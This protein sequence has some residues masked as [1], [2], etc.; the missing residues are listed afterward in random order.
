LE[1]LEQFE[2][3]VEEVNCEVLIAYNHNF[4]SN[5]SEALQLVKTGLIGIPRSIHVRWLEHWGGIF[6]AH[7]WLDGPSDTYLGFSQRGGGAC[8]E[9]SHAI[10]L[11]QLFASELGLGQV[12]S[13]FAMMDI[14]NEGGVD[15]DRTAQLT[16]RTT[17]GFTGTVI[18]D[19]VTEPAEKALRIQGDG[20]YLEWYVNY[21]SHNDAL[22]YSRKDEEPTTRLFP[23]ARPDD[24]KSQIDYI[25]DLLMGQAVQS[26]NTLSSGVE[27]MRIVSAAHKSNEQSSAISI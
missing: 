6:Q 12:Q 14:D 15:Y 27:T 20:G 18:Q 13:V 4:T 5:T 16:L 25:G 23:K 8:A 24:F 2:R 17:T 22:I 9:H 26:R 21:D 7:P 10:S 19:V 1:N 11:W 3:Q